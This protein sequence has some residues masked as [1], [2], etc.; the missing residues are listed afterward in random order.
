MDVVVPAFARRFAVTS[1]NECVRSGCAVYSILRTADANGHPIDCERLLLPL[2]QAAVE[3]IVASV[4]LVSVKGEF[5]RNVV[6]HKFKAQ[7]DVVLSGKIE[8]TFQPTE[9]GNGSR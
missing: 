7:L 1:A 5:R 9:I 6:L 4:Q 8:K 3:Q 2:G